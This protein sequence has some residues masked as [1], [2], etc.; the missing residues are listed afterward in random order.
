M[1][2][3]AASASAKSGVGGG[4][5]SGTLLAVFKSETEAFLWDAWQILG[6]R[7]PDFK[8][9]LEAVAAGASGWLTVKCCN[10]AR[11]KA[12]IPPSSS[13]IAAP[14]PAVDAAAAAPAVPSAQGAPASSAG[15]GDG[16]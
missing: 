14:T 11:P 16:V 8:T 4:G 9:E 6:D 10:D 15:N 1:R 5:R 13:T 2:P 12:H 3:S 7:T